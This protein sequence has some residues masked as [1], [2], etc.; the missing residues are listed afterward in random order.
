MGN[1]ESALLVR[2]QLSFNKMRGCGEVFSPLTF[3]PFNLFPVR[4]LTHFQLFYFSFTF[5]PSIELTILLN[6][7]FSSSVNAL[8]GSTLAVPSVA[9]KR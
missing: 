1:R 2:R 7:V 3:L 5:K 4:L 9:F 6:S 8:L